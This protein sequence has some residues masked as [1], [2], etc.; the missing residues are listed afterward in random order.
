LRNC[1]GYESKKSGGGKAL[2]RSAL[3]GIFAKHGP[4]SLSLQDPACVD[5]GFV[6]AM[7]LVDVV[8]PATGRASLRVRLF[9]STLRLG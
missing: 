7:E 6:V 1:L 3:E 9:I 4:M 5:K 2:S 8:D